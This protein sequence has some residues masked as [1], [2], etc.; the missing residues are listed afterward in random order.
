MDEKEFNYEYEKIKNDYEIIDKI[1]V[2]SK[3]KLNWYEYYT[4][5]YNNFIIIM[6][7]IIIYHYYFF[8][9]CFRY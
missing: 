2:S 6:I 3:K 7:V 9:K 1:N 4:K 5:L 8:K